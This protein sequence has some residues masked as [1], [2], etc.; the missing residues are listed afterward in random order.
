MQDLTKAVSSEVDKDLKR[1]QTT[2]PDNKHVKKLKLA[3]GKEKIQNEEK[4][5]K[6]SKSKRVINQIL[7]SKN[8]DST[9]LDDV[10]GFDLGA[11]SK[12]L[13]KAI[14]QGAD[15]EDNSEVSILFPL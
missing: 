9:I 5:E 11:T 14:S 7:Q 6:T 12:D 10:G 8:D 15:E 2:Q 1:K 3:N 4:L 13:T